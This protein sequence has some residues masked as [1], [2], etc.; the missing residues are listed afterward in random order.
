VS[1]IRLT[2]KIFCPCFGE[3]IYI[4]AIIES[5]RVNLEMLIEKS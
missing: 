3:Y 4:Y 5:V 2:F 1:K